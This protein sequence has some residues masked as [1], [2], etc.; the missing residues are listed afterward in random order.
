MINFPYLRQTMRSNLRLWLPFTLI[1]CVFLIVMCNVFTPTNI[2]TLG[3]MADGSFAGNLLSGGTLVA[4]MS[5]SYYALMAILFPMLYSILAGNGLIAAKVDNGS[6]AGYLATP[7]SRTRIVCS[8]ALYLI[9]SLA[10]MWIVI[11]LVGVAAAQIAQPGELDF[12]LFL[13]LNLGAFLY[14]F[15]I[16]SICFFASC[17]FDSSSTSLLVGGGIPLLF[18]VISLLVKLSD[19]LEVLKYFTLNTLFDT[20]AILQGEGYGAD[21]AVLAVIGILFYSAGILLFRKR[22]LPL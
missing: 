6:M 7:V 16:S 3:D 4:F 14:H 2:S 9:G 21:F 20:V 10:A 12:V 22:D 17:L 18:F 5:N 8:S 15:A 13:R 19:S 11:S 1:S